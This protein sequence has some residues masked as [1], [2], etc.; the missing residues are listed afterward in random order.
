MAKL[1]DRDVVSICEK[2]ITAA[3]GFVHGELS[4]QR[5]DAMERYLGEPLGNEQDGRSQ[6]LTREVLETIESMMP[7]LIRLFTDVKNVVV[8]DPVGPEDE[9]QADQEMDVMNHVLWKQNSGFW[10]M[11]SLV[12]DGLLSKTGIWKVYWDDAKTEEREE[13]Q[14]LNQIELAQLMMDDAVD[15]E[16][17]EFDQREDGL[18]D[19]VFKA[20]RDKGQVRILSVPPEE[21][22]VNRD[23]RSPFAKD[24]NFVYHRVRKTRSELLE[25]G[26]D[27]KTVDEIPA[28]DDVET[29]ERLA[30]RHLDDE[31]DVIRFGSHKSM[32]Y[33]WVT[34]CYMKIDRDD[35]G[36]AELLKI[37]LATGA[38]NVSTGSILLDVEE[39]EAIP[40]HCFAPI[41]LT[42]KF[43][44]LS[45]ADLACDIQEQQTALMRGML[46]AMYLALNQRMAVSDKVN[47][48]DVTTSRPGGIIRF[49]RSVTGE[50]P[51]DHVLPIPSQPPPQE[52]YALIEHLDTQLK[53][54]TGVSDAT[55]ALDVGALSNINTGVAA[56][57]FDNARAKLELVARNCAEMCIAPAMLD[58]HRLLQQHQSK[59]LT[60]KIRNDWVQ[61]S[62]SEW[63]ERTNTTVKV[64]I[65]Q[66]SRE[67]RAMA[68]D[69]LLNKQVAAA[70][71]GA[72]GMFLLPHNM[73][74][75]V[76]DYTEALGLEPDLYWTDPATIPPPQEPEG[77]SAEEQQ[78]MM[79]AEI[80]KGKL[81]VEAEKTAAR[82]E[83]VQINAQIKAAELE[84][85]RDE[86]ALRGQVD[87]LKAE[88][89]AIEGARKAAG[90]ADKAM[91]DAQLKATETALKA[92]ELE[93]K[94]R[95]DTNDKALEKY[96]ADLSASVDIW[97]T[98][99]QAAIGAAQ[100]ERDAAK[101]EQGRASANVVDITEQLAELQRQRAQPLKVER[102]ASGR[103]SRSAGGASCATRTA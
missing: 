71:N 98:E 36:I 26:Y 38:Q 28:D 8:F 25:E 86:L 90:E 65:G 91:L 102:D 70:M 4:N 19:V 96:K 31:Q 7:S 95:Q 40:F 57:A 84:L 55:A 24:C 61:V 73:H 20:T 17:V 103:P 99:Y 62:P 68:L 14:G 85:R 9:A 21:F 51:G 82:R 32:E 5:A 37:T 49:K 46:D 3:S 50:R 64:G 101:S 15:R 59:P 27:R 53:Q 87:G 89:T 83:E 100:A 47:L 12:K 88:M 56:M 48:D 11:Y 93:L 76:E 81:Q 10:L 44:G 22:G 69:D 13:Y 34:E 41:P 52:A 35:D 97:K 33:V 80:E 18:V 74:K 60:V 23:A 6:V 39:V 75:A 77:P 43:Y 92:A 1:T 2:E 42:H 67:R 66:S 45:E 78:M 63:R 58:I 16:V 54:R 29:E 72:M 30:R 79:L 94:Q